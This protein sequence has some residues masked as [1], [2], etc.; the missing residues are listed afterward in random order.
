MLQVLSEML[1]QMLLDGAGWVSGILNN[2][3]SSTNQADADNSRFDLEVR[4]DQEFDF[5]QR[6]EDTGGNVIGSPDWEGKMNTINDDGLAN[7]APDQY[8]F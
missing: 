2:N 3:T 8:S 6:Q 5:E 7:T 1:C 4:T